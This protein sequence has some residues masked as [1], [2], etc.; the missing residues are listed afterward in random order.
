MS[1]TTREDQQ[2][3][4][5]FAAILRDDTGSA[6]ALPPVRR[7]RRF[8]RWLVIVC[9]LLAAAVLVAT[10]V[11]SRLISDPAA[12]GN[13]LTE[14]ARKADLVIS[15]TEDGTLESSHN[16][17]IKCEVQGGST[18]LWIVRD[19]TDVKKGD[20]LVRLDSAGIQEKIDLQKILQLVRQQRY[21]RLRA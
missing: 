1:I 13:Y 15:I 10:T 12:T 4:A 6:A 20:E 16:T 7:R 21:R 11:G 17:D 14:K 2:H 3:A 19:G 8:P 9:M 18:I 5:K